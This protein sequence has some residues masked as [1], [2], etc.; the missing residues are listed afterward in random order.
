MKTLMI[1]IGENEPGM[2]GGVYM[3]T[4]MISTEEKEPGTAEGALMRAR[5]IQTVGRGHGITT[6]S[7]S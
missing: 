3:N 1:P 2:P 7:P 4:L 5:D 6:R